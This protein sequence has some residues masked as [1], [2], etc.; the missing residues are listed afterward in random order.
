MKRLL[1]VLCMVSVVLLLSPIATNA[2]VANDPPVADAGPDQTVGVGQIATLDGSASY[3]PDG[4]VLI[5][6]W[7]LLRPSGSNAEITHSDS[8][9]ATFTPDVPGAYVAQLIVDD[10]SESRADTTTI[11]A[12]SGKTPLEMAIEAIEQLQTDIAPMPRSAFRYVL[13]KRLLT[14]ELNLVIASLEMRRYRVALILLKNNILPTTDGCFKNN[15]PDRQDW[16][17]DCGA[18]AIVYPELQNIIAM[19]KGM[20]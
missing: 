15:A 4:A 20:L 8:D 7:S 14:L 2:A 9:V 17:V 10:G 19:V 16:I 6:S 12:E 18:Q 5:Y 3:D 11:H 1:M 13:S